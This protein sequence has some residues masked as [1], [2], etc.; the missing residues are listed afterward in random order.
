MAPL[1]VTM[2]T[3][4]N[5]SFSPGNILPV[6][7]DQLRPSHG[8]APSLSSL[9][10]LSLSLS[11]SISFIS[12]LFYLYLFISISFHSLFHLYL[13]ISISSSHLF[14]LYPFYLI[15]LVLISSSLSPSSHPS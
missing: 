6:M 3:P 10:L 15:H 13:F 14:H 8:S 5:F 1:P 7:K 12:Y 11:I 9:S 2:F 4:L